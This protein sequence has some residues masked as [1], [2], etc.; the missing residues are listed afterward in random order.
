M[1]TQAQQIAME[2]FLCEEFEDFEDTMQLLR[3]D[4]ID[5]VWESVKTSN[6]NLACTIELL[7]KNI[8]KALDG[9]K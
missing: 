1:A 2:T 5:C 9:V 8:Q 6:S 7:A 4:E 3:N